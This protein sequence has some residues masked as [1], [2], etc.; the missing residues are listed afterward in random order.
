[1]FRLSC[2]GFIGNLKAHSTQSRPSGQTA[3]IYHYLSHCSSIV[4]IK[5]V[6]CTQYCLP[7]DERY[8]A[9]HPGLPILRRR[10]G[11]DR[12]SIQLEGSCNQRRPL[13]RY[14]IVSPTIVPVLDKLGHLS[15]MTRYQAYNGRESLICTTN[16][17]HFTSNQ[18]YHGHGR[19]AQGTTGRFCC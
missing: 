1:M 6:G 4:I 3:S 11:G 14:Q 2:S 13:T 15:T 12:P 8:G 9:W 7:E 5:V 10:Y 19:Q 16:S 18:R 17:K